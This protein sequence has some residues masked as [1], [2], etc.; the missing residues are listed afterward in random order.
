ML[1]SAPL[2]TY[3]ARLLAV[4]ICGSGSRRVCRYYRLEKL[5][6]L[7][8]H[9]RC[10]GSVLP[11]TD[12]T[13]AAAVCCLPCLFSWKPRQATPAVLHRPRG[14]LRMPCLPTGGGGG[15]GVPTSRDG[16]ARPWP[17]HFEGP[18][19]GSGDWASR[20][21]RWSLVLPWADTT[22]SSEAVSALGRCASTTPERLSCE[23]LRGLAWRWGGCC[24]SKS[25]KLCGVALF[26]L[27]PAVEE[28]VAGAAGCIQAAPDTTASRP[29]R[30]LD[31]GECRGWCLFV[32]VRA[33]QAVVELRGGGSSSSLLPDW[34]FV[35]AAQRCPRGA[36]AQGG[37]R[38]RPS[39]FFGFER[40][41][42]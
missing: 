33:W 39:D 34:L 30:G 40:A 19:P 14:A 11:G 9:P 26:L 24:K 25:Q 29:E 31:S 2:A 12:V 4:V 1:S 27:A 6:V 13:A 17:P 21:P 36:G 37:E 23:P 7:C 35:R 20:A 5:L 3:L 28:A 41:R 38:P 16:Y 10:W 22:P 18:R 15:E 8:L 32:S 42:R